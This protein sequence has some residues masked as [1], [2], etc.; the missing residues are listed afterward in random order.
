MLHF[1]RALLAMRRAHVALR[2]GSFTTLQ[3]D[4][5]VLV[6]SRVHEDDAVIV[7]FNLGEAPRTVELAQPPKSTGAA[8]SVGDVRLDGSRLALGPWSAWLV[9]V[10]G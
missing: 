5:Q 6:V 2:L 10:Q 7:A 3:A 1:T 9:A 8:V 4:E